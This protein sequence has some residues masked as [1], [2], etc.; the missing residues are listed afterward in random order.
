MRLTFPHS[1][2]WMI[3]SMLSL[4]I[5]SKSISVISK[6]AAKSKSNKQKT[7]VK[8]NHRTSSTRRHDTEILKSSIDSLTWAE[9]ER[10]LALYFRDHGYYVEETGIGGN[11][12]GVDLVIVDK[13]T[14]ERTAIQAKHWNDHRHVGPNIIRELHSARMNTK[15][16]CHYAM[17]ITSSDVT[18]QARVEAR[19]RRIE[20][21]HGA[22]L[23]Y[24]LQQW[25]KWKG[26]RQKRYK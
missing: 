19:E 12:G 24:K 5:V 2:Y 25:D 18:H 11:D 20:F 23:Q 4:T 14:K 3:I 17:L 8:G 22:M 7:S 13:R 9:F 26:N 10:L 21:W 6:G 15:P 1:I 16:A